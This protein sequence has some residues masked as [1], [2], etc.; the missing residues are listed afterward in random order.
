MNSNT[1]LGKLSKAAGLREPVDWTEGW[2]WTW[3]GRR[4]HVKDDILGRRVTNFAGHMT[5]VTPC[6]QMI[7]MGPVVEDPEV[8]HHRLYSAVSSKDRQWLEQLSFRPQITTCDP[9][10]WEAIHAGIPIYK[11]KVWYSPTRLQDLLDDPSWIESCR[12][13]WN[14]DMDKR[15]LN[16]NTFCQA[17]RVTKNLPWIPKMG[18]FHE[19]CLEQQ[20]TK[21]TIVE[22]RTFP[23]NNRDFSLAR[24]AAATN[25]LRS[26]CM[27]AS[28]FASVAKRAVKMI[29]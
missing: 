3:R 12:F 4:T 21:N 17:W 25:V 18:R 23:L 2:I 10:P 9:T 19:W 24:Q 8:L 16:C 5:L 6:E 22:N 15:Q 7:S 14:V 27:D 20:Q 1:S 29:A 11:T 13:S 26:T 28:Y